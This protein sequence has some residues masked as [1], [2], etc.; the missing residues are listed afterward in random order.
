MSGQPESEDLGRIVWL[1]SYPK[2][3]NTWL[4]A[5]LAN[6]LLDTP[7]PVPLDRLGK[8]A[9]A[10]AS[11]S[12][13][14]QF[15]ARAGIPLDDRAVYRWRPQVQRMLARR[16]RSFVFVKT[17][18]AL[19]LV[20]QVPTIAPEVTAGAVYVVR[21][22][23]DVAV[24]F[25]RHMGC[26]LNEGIGAMG[27][28]QTELPIVENLVHEYLG[29][30]SDHVKSWLEAPGLSPYL[31]RYEDLARDPE[32]SFGELTAFLRLPQDPARLKKAVAFS[33]FEQLAAQE[34][35]AGFAERPAGAERFFRSGKV[36]AWREALSPEQAERIVATH[37]P[38]M[39]RLGYLDSDG[40]LVF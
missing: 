33:R 9:P 25:S 12:P 35:A 8:F 29:G 22:P 5:L 24:S 6:Y 17:H 26:A 21:N 15:A 4:R 14:D 3:G 2:S 36:G 34:V 39:R 40:A 20:N 18:A 13:Y 10:E 31:L 11:R 30:W 1:A 37:G 16:A 19:T 32:R 28:D 7:Q 38:A 23:L 27:S